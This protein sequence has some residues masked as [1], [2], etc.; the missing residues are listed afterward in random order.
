[1]HDLRR[2]SFV[3]TCKFTYLESLVGFVLRI[4]TGGFVFTG[5]LNTFLSDMI[6]SQKKSPNFGT[7]F[8]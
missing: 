7:W 3:H 5:K 4:E 2:E 6:L 1:M 8:K